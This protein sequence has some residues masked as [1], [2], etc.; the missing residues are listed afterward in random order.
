MT[1]L[2]CML[3]VKDISFAGEIMKVPMQNDEERQEITHKANHFHSQ[4]ST[5]HQDVEFEEN[6]TYNK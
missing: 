2:K 5:S 3:F 6:L 4:G 1:S